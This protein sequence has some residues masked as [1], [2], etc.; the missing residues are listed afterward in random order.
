[1]SAAFAGIPQ[2][3]DQGTHNIT[4]GATDNIVGVPA[5]NISFVLYVGDAL[6]TQTFRQGRPLNYSVPPGTFAVDGVTFRYH[7][8]LSTGAALPVWL[9]FN[10]QTLQLTGIPPFNISDL[11]ELQIIAQDEQNNDTLTAPV[12]WVIQSNS[13]LQVNPISIQTATVGD[14]FSLFVAN[15][16][17]STN[18]DSLT[19]QASQVGGGP[20]PG[21]LN[22]NG[23]PQAPVFLASPDTATPIFMRCAP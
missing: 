12:S 23:T 5:V 22:F 13:P 21:W 14:A 15:T 3:V 16:F 8:S 1:M 4:I 17:T 11:L 20:L 6:P 19:Y 10:P 7:A 9:A 18:G 2:E